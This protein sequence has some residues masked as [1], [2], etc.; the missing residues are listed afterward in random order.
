MRPPN[1]VLYE[2]ELYWDIDEQLKKT[3][4]QRMGVGSFNK[5]KFNLIFVGAYETH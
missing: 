5:F 2:L 4:L 3:K 1:C